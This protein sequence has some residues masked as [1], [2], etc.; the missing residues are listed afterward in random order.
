[1]DWDL[2]TILEWLAGSYLL[3]RSVRDDDDGVTVHHLNTHSEHSSFWR[4]YLEDL[5]NNSYDEGI[6]GSALEIFRRIWPKKEGSTSWVN[7]WS[8]L[9]LRPIEKDA[10]SIHFFCGVSFSPQM[11]G[12]GSYITHRS[13]NMA[14]APEKISNANWLPQ[15][16]SSNLM[17]QLYCIGRQIRQMEKIREIQSTMTSVIVALA[18]HR[19]ALTLNI[20][21]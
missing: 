6:A 1:M 11:V 13:M 2:K 16:P 3:E 7:D 14:Q 10:V 8:S 12:R 21:T 4:H 19:K 18:G 17:S 5:D 15:W 20:S 9:P